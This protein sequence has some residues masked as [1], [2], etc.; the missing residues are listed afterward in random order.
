MK[1]ECKQKLIK[2]LRKIAKERGL[3]VSFLSRIKKQE[4]YADLKNRTVEIGIG[5]PTLTCS[6]LASMF[7]HELAHFECRKRRKFK[8]FHTARQRLSRKDHL[9]IR[10]TGLRAELYVDKVGEE[11][12]KDYF[13]NY[14]FGKSYSTMQL[15]VWLQDFLRTNYP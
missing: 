2:Q 14:R 15:K 9:A 10:R 3:K 7:F 4:A 5:D 1:M 11:I 13:P 8:R 12:M 6:A